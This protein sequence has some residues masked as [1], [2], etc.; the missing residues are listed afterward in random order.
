ML[1]LAFLV[2]IPVQVSAVESTEFPRKLQ[3]TAIT[4]TVRIENRSRDEEGSG[5]I[6]GRKGRF[7]YILTAAHLV[8]PDDRLLVATFS[9][10]SYPQVDKVYRSAQVVATLGDIRDL[11]LIRIPTRDEPP[12]S[13]KV[14]PPQTIPEK[15]NFPGLAVGC[16]EGEAPT[17]SVDRIIGK[18]LVRRQGKGKPGYLWEVSR[19]HESGRSGGPLIDRRGYLLGICSGTNKQKSYFCHTEGIRAFL[20]Q[21]GIE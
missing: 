6:I 14:C 9:R 13:L 12:G 21:N 8:S 4:A 1:A 16:T 17:C 20:K 19:K 5:T 3:M 18:K 7:I 15:K 11:A 2:L 10:T